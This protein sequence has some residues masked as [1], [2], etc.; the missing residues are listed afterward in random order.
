MRERRRLAMMARLI[1]VQRSA[2]EGAEIA[3]ASTRSRAES[4]RA[5]ESEALAASERAQEDW[6]AFVTGDAFS[7]DR[8]RLLAHEAVERDSQAQAA[9]ASARAWEQ[10]EA[11]REGEW[12]RREAEV[13]ASE[14]S[15][16]SARRRAARRQ[17][18]KRLGE[19]TDRTTFSWKRK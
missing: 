8:S 12:R 9:V 3:L 18:E 6:I 1:E 2:R 14:N 17:E 13:R 15:L 4:S 5:E 11:R 19:L 16:R 7:P 10:L